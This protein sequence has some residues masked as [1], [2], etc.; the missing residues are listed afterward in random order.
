MLFKRGEAT[1][2]PH[3]HYHPLILFSVAS[4]TEAA[5]V[6]TQD[7]HI[8]TNT[9]ATSCHCRYSNQQ[10]TLQPETRGS[11]W[12]ETP[13]WGCEPRYQILSPNKNASYLLL[14]CILQFNSMCTYTRGGRVISH[15]MGLFCG[16]A[17]DVKYI[18][19]HVKPDCNKYMFTNTHCHSSKLF[20]VQLLPAE[21]TSHGKSGSLYDCT[22]W[23]SLP[24]QWLI[25]VLPH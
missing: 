9:H 25:K 12:H 6:Y 10:L 2:H 11:H 7:W 20:S 18:S 3:P 24:A 15:S 13:S 14:V 17:K 4:K 8:H 5:I 21:C 16:Y 1:P 19:K 23:H 22:G